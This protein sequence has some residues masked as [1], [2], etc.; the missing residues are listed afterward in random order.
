MIQ[1]KRPTMYSAKKLKLEIKKDLILVSILSA[2]VSGW[3]FFTAPRLDSRWQYNQ[4]M[5]LLQVSSWSS[6]LSHL[7]LHLSCSYTH[8]KRLKIDNIL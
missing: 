8:K 4:A 7:E 2:W 1:S 3:L 6:T 5:T